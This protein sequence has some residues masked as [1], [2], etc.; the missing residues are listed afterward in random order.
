MR[1]DILA[2]TDKAEQERRKE[3]QWDTR[4]YAEV[5]LERYGRDCDGPSYTKPVN[6]LV[7]EDELPFILADHFGIGGWT[8]EQDG[9]ELFLDRRDKTD[10]GYSQL[11]AHV[12]FPEPEASES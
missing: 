6:L 10:E 5:K 3:L 9:R 4:E 2:I 1:I 12:Y 7:T 11:D 8:Y